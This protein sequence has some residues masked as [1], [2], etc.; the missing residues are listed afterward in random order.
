MNKLVKEKML[1]LEDSLARTA[2]AMDRITSVEKAMRNPEEFLF[3]RER[4]RFTIT[5]YKIAWD[6]L[7]VRD[8]FGAR[9]DNSDWTLEE[10][11]GENGIANLRY[12]LET[13]T[14]VENVL[15][16][17]E[18]NIYEDRKHKKEEES[19]FTKS[20][21][22]RSAW[23][24]VRNVIQKNLY[25][26]I[27]E[28][29][30]R[31]AINWEETVSH[32]RFFSLKNKSRRNIN[33]LVD[34][35]S[36]RDSIKIAFGYRVRLTMRSRASVLRLIITDYLHRQKSTNGNCRD[37]ELDFSLS[38]LE[39]YV[40]KLDR[41]IIGNMKDDDLTD[42]E[43]L[44]LK[45]KFYERGKNKINL[46]NDHDY[47]H[48][49]ISMLR[50]M[51]GLSKFIPGI[52][53]KRKDTVKLGTEKVTLKRLSDNV[54]IDPNNDV[55]FEEID[56]N[57]K[58]V[59]R[60]EVQKVIDVTDTRSRKEKRKQKKRD[61]VQSLQDN[62]YGLYANKNEQTKII[63]V[64]RIAEVITSTKKD[65]ALVERIVQSGMV[66]KNNIKEYETTKVRLGDIDRMINKFE[67][68]Y[69]NNMKG[70]TLENL[71]NLLTKEITKILVEDIEYYVENEAMDFQK[72]QIRKGLM[73]RTTEKI[74]KSC[75]ER[76]LEKNL[77]LKL[78]VNKDKQVRDIDREKI[79][80][81]CNIEDIEGIKQDAKL[82]SKK[83]ADEV[84]IIKKNYYRL[85]E[86][87]YNRDVL[88]VLKEK[89]YDNVKETYER[90][91]DEKKMLTEKAKELA[92]DLRSDSKIV[93][94][95]KNDLRTLE[96]DESSFEENFYKVNF[97]CFLL[98][99]IN[100][101]KVHVNLRPYIKK[102]PKS[103]RFYRQGDYIPEHI[104]A[105]V[106]LDYL[107]WP[108]DLNIISINEDV[109]WLNRRMKLHNKRTKDNSNKI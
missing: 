43:T 101:T 74:I 60:K 95:M 6:E 77:Y 7:K 36:S 25:K 18:F 34:Y 28:K 44:R 49:C 106:G 14:Y 37:P 94:T 93:K 96:N 2:W 20:N 29:P 41:I 76:H 4:L 31:V 80:T 91:V 79:K 98:D 78:D 12:D 109:T 27:N 97:K 50:F 67:E 32:I 64:D 82:S 23:K 88:K 39:K 75:L 54:Y 5:D 8:I 33:K 68:K 15:S 13:F 57:G 100:D 45:R 99:I 63:E 38:D 107:D 52:S 55:V 104:L 26:I 56:D 69:A 87:V 19:D 85:L 53:F 3:L 21:N 10:A 73:Q 65:V 58:I 22:K 17:H 83:L 30:C 103:L 42:N 66:I 48:Q 86:R 89:Q 102:Y 108:L 105:K 62:L 40:S 61:M 51:K 46:S 1:T 84:D 90:L 59:E 24:I 70:F 71:L 11:Y 92:M 9:I 47:F 72:A 81:L 35:L 16:R